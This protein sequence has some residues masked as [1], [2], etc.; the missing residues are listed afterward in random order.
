MRNP[1]DNSLLPIFSRPQ[2]LPPNTGWWSF[3]LKQTSGG[4][5]QNINS[6]PSEL[7]G[8]QT[9]F[10]ILKALLEY[11]LGIQLCSIE[12]A[13][14][15]L[16]CY[17][18]VRQNGLPFSRRKCRCHTEELQREPFGTNNKR[19]LLQTLVRYG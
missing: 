17:S 4:C 3:S 8:K 1:V 2:M 11:C 10:G 16:N 6:H 19:G 7:Q 18:G 13:K 12:P 14:G 9:V 5:G 15:L